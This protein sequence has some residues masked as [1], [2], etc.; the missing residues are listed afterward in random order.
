[1]GDQISGEQP[2]ID[3]LESLVELF[4]NPG[5]VKDVRDR[6]VKLHYT[7]IDDQLHPEQRL[8]VHA[9]KQ[10]FRIS[11][12]QTS[13]FVQALRPKRLK[14]LKRMLEDTLTL[15]KRIAANE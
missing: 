10:M 15:M 13:D 7:D 6:I 4:E 2:I 9:L 8:Q 14:S 11:G 3:E 1:M 12:E 5:K